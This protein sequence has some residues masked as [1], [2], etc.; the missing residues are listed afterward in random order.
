[1]PPVLVLTDPACLEHDSGPGH[2]E[3][4]ARVTAA[5][6]GI[7]RAGLGDDAVFDRP[8]PATVEELARIHDPEYIEGI[9]RFCAKGGGWLTLDTGAGPGSWDAALAAAGAP[10]DAVRRGGP[11]F[12]A[13]RPPG[14]HATARHAQGFCLFNNVAVAAA[15]VEG[16]VLIVDWDVHHGN[17]TQDTFYADDRVLYVSFHQWPLYPFTGRLEETGVGAGDGYTINFPFPAGATGDVYQAALDEVVAPA[18]AAFRPDWLLVSCGFDSHR[19]D[20]LLEETMGLTAGDFA[21][22]TRRCMALAPPGRCVVVLE[23]GYHTDAVARS[24]AACVA[25][26]AGRDDVVPPAPDVKTPAEGPSSGGPG[27]DV[28]EA[29]AR[30]RA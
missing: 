27:M 17:G 11:A 6:E 5:V 25:A 28:V 16:R 19:D 30:L 7:Q 24:A 29:A 1:M 4:P 14:H 22:L 23:G 13:V 2:P 20:I 12:C 9:R 3:R 18:A 21:A 15:A 10:I 8:R 26:L